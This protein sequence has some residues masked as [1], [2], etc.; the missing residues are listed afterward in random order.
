MIPF[1]AHDSAQSNAH[2]LENMSNWLVLWLEVFL[3]SPGCDPE[4]PLNPFGTLRWPCC[5][6]CHRRASWRRWPRP[7][8]SRVICPLGAWTNW[9]SGC[10]HRPR[11]LS[12]WRPNQPEPTNDRPPSCPV[13]CSNE[14]Q[15]LAPI[16]ASWTCHPTPLR[17]FMDA[18]SS[19]NTNLIAWIEA[20]SGHI[21]AADCLDLFNGAKTLVVQYLNGEWMDGWEKKGSKNWN[22]IGPYGVCKCMCLTWSKSNMISL[23]RRIHSTPLFT[24]SE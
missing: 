14:T 11:T 12:C 16:Y 6:K 17:G 13:M 22:P 10:W 19:P 15:L 5:P 20:R 3:F 1:G 23:R 21:S 7:P 9:T 18:S 2:F 8:D 24:S 4:C